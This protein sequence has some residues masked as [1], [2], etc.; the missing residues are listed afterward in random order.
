[1][2]VRKSQEAK[3]DHSLRQW[4][5]FLLSNKNTFIHILLRVSEFLIT[6]LRLLVDF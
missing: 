3:A 1:M 4:D 5:P 2:V 6:L